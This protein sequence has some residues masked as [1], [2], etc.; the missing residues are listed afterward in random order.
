MLL[1]SFIS[2]FIR[3]QQ[4]S[5]RSQKHWHLST[6]R[7]KESILLA[8]CYCRSAVVVVGTTCQCWQPLSL[9]SSRTNFFFFFR[10]YFLV[11]F[12]LLLFRA[13][14]MHLCFIHWFHCSCHAFRA[15]FV[16][17]RGGTNDRTRKNSA[18]SVTTIDYIF[19]RTLHSTEVNKN[20][21]SELRLL[22][23]VP[24]CESPRSKNAFEILELRKQNS[25][26]WT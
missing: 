13:L 3:T 10:S 4:F 24:N 14:S 1:F 23:I 22:C 26:N 18:H 2:N 6:F 16:A 21:N 15:H 11:L 12:S 19:F 20:M 5:M 25:R 7:F 17:E 9:Q 8:G